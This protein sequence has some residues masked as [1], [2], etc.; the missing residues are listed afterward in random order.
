[1][2][3]ER[4]GQKKK[5]SIVDMAAEVSAPGFYQKSYCKKEKKKEKLDTCC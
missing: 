3:Q 5:K 4:R 2:L 1:M